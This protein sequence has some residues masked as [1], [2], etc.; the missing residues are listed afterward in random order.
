MK[1]AL[2]LFMIVGF[3]GGFYIHS[4]QPQLWAQVA[5]LWTPAKPAAPRS[6]FPPVPLPQQA[7][8]TWTTSDGH[9]YRNVVIQKVEA[10]CVTIL[11]Y[12]GGARIDI[13]TLP[14][15][16]QNQL[17]Y[18]P[19]LA[20]EASA[21]RNQDDSASTA[22]MEKER[23]QGEQ[24]AQS[25][26]AELDP[27]EP[28]SAGSSSS[29]S[30]GVSSSET[31]RVV[32]DEQAYIYE[33][34]LRY[35]MGHIRINP[36]TGRAEGDAYYLRKYEED[37]RCIALHEQAHNNA[38]RASSQNGGQSPG[39]SGSA[40]SAQGTQNNR[41]NNA[42]NQKSNTAATPSV[43]KEP[44]PPVTKPATASSTAPPKTPLPLTTP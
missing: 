4:Q 44:P 37:K 11:D 3:G 21:K 20:A 8:W 38:Q 41:P 16:I 25:K 14:V 22:E 42:I 33:T 5:A 43:P 29:V 6:F 31:G 2:L 12:D 36:T 9:T 15:D 40:T 1:Y 39:V 30:V 13:S 17:N 26:L 18:D 28:Q 35:V 7:N 10:D 27:T 32:T 23:V 24:V 19:E 34:D